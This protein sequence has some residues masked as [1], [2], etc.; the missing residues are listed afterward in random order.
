MLDVLIGE[1]TTTG[2]GVYLDYKDRPLGVAII[3]S[4]DGEVVA[5]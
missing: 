5:P 4:R 2:D 3:G 1:D